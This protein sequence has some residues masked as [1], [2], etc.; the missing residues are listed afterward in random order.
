PHDEPGVPRGQRRGA[1]RRATGQIRRDHVHGNARARAGPGVGSSGV[2]HAGQAGG[3]GLLFDHQPQSK[4]VPVCDHWCGICAQLAAPGYPRVHEV[5]SPERAGRLLPR[6]RSGTRTHPG[7]AIQPADPAL[8]AV[9]GYQRELS[10]RDAE[11]LMFSNIGAVLFDLDGTLID[12][13]PD[14]GAAADKM[15]VARGMPSLP[16]EQYRPMAGAGA[17]GMLGVAF[18]MTP[19][20]PDFAELREEFFVNYET[21]MTERTYAFRGIPELI[22]QLLARG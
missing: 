21:C 20:H 19:D 12:S 8:L 5:R 1:G 15:R 22:S 3:L 10:L 7:H 6:Q 9:W 17:R 18:G 2:R 4:V 11:N 13:A 16:L 14:L